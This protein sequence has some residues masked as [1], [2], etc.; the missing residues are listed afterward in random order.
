MTSPSGLGAYEKVAARSEPDELRIARKQSES[1][2]FPLTVS[3]ATLGY[4][5][6]IFV[7]PTVDAAR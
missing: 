2:E 5:L 6:P 3:A 4:M 7:L 1:N